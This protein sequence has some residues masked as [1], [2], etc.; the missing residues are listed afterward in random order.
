MFDN[1]DQFYRHE[2]KISIETFGKIRNKDNNSDNF[3]LAI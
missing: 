2:K 1:H 3:K